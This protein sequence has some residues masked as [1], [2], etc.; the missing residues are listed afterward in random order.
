MRPSEA[1][2]TIGNDN[3]DIVVVPDGL[4]RHPKTRKPLARPSFVYRAVLDHVIMQFS[5]RRIYLAP[6]N[7]FGGP[8]SEQQAAA[9]YLL[10]AG[11]ADLVI[12]PTMSTGYIDTRGNAADLKDFLTEIGA[13]PLHPVLL[14]TAKRHAPRAA[15]CFRKEGY[16]IAAVHAVDYTIPRLEEVVSRLW[17]Y[18]YPRLHLIYEALAYCRDII[19]RPTK[20]I[21]Y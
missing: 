5:N 17:Y 2:K 4:A 20:K 21:V 16:I 1:H 10:E 14:I 19:R 18:K 8:I 7:T 9:D 15:L 6:A 12:C 11:T 3:L 13:W